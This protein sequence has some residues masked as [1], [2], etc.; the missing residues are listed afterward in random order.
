MHVLAIM[1]AVTC[2]AGCVLAIATL[3]VAKAPPAAY[4]AAILGVAA[5]GGLI[6]SLIIIGL[7]VS[8]T[9]TRR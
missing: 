5:A 3:A 8:R 9:Q 6:I 4:A 2:V 7:T 1:T